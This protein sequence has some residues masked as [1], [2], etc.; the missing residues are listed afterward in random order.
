MNRAQA[1]AEIE[2]LIRWTAETFAEGRC[3]RC[4][5]LAFTAWGT[6][7]AVVDDTVYN[8][9]SDADIAH[10]SDDPVGG[11]VDRVE[12]LCNR[13]D[14]EIE[15]GLLPVGAGTMIGPIAV[16]VSEDRARER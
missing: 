13:F 6:E 7:H 15:F 2:Q 5:A 14:L 1:L 8:V 3:V 16:H 4:E 10:A 12:E 9:T 11:A